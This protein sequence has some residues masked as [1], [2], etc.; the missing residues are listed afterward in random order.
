MLCLRAR[1]RVLTS[2]LP[3]PPPLADPVDRRVSTVGRVG[4]H[5]E[6]RVA[7]PATGR[8]LPRGQVRRRAGRG[9][10]HG[11][12]LVVALAVL[13]AAWQQ[14]TPH[15]LPAG[16]RRP[17]CRCPPRWVSCWCEATP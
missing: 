6:A 16:H 2:R 4:P 9:G 12:L 15:M 17:P 11:S 3:S 13:R 10:H 5:L 7:D 14:R 1:R 8:T